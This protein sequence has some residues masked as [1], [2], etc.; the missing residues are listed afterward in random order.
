MTSPLNRISTKAV[1]AALPAGLSRR[2]RPDQARDL[3]ATLELR[4]GGTPFTIRVQGGRCAVTRGAAADAGAWIAVSAG[5]VVR[6][7][8]GDVTWPRLLGA[9]RLELGGDP[10]LALRFPGMFGLTSPPPSRPSTTAPA[11]A[12]AAP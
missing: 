11:A 4:V 2:F 3:D 7:L 9:R 8:T 5:D 6:L 10:Y 1:L 12:A